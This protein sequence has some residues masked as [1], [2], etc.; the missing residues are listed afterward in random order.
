MIITYLILKLT[1]Q[2]ILNECNRLAGEQQS[3]EQM[4]G[5][6]S[7]LLKIRLD[8]ERGA[9]SEEEYDKMQNKI[10]KSLGGKV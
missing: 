8:Y 3:R 9:I 5:L 4:I 10:L 1:F 7:R 6:K 2:S